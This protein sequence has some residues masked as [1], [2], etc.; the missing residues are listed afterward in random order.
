MERA[1]QRQ[2][3]PPSGSAAAAADYY[4]QRGAAYLRLD[5]PDLTA[6]HDV[7]VEAL[8]QK[9]REDG[10][11][12]EIFRKKAAGC[13]QTIACVPGAAWADAVFPDLPQDRR[14]DALW[15]AVLQCTRC[16]EPDP[17]QAWMNY[18][19]HT[20]RRKQM[21][22]NKGYTAFHYH[23]EG[24]DLTICPAQDKWKGSCVRSE[25]RVSVPNIPTEE[26]FLTPHK[27]RVDGT[28]VSTMPLNYKGRL[29]EGIELEFREGRIIRHTAKRG[30]ELLAA[31]IET[32]EGSH[33]I[34]EMAL[35]DQAS[36][37]ARLNRVFYT[38][39]YDENASCHIAIGSALGRIRDPGEREAR[40][41]NT[42][43]VHVDFMVG[44]DTL[45]IDG[46]LPSGQWEPVFQN[47]RWAF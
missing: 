17:I 28:V 5:S 44:S 1:R 31:I 10:Q 9:A 13:G 22:D 29:I 18:L 46:L 8:A 27:Y 3:M 38:T 15:D 11:V 26:V 43:S 25:D 47:G 23:G 36:P 20:A 40:G 7:P 34:G 30:A 41:M 16:K 37:I 14:M 39:L 21:L 42:S 6:F 24:T 35:V 33:Y 45:C 4:A 19:D 32:D 12:R 2:P